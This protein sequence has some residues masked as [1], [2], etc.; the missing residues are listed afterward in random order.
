MDGKKKV[1]AIADNCADIYYKLNRF[2]VTGNSINFALNYKALGGDV[3]CMTILG[4]DAFALTLQ[5]LLSERDVPLKVLKKVDRPSAQ[6][7]MDIVDGN[8]IHV[9]FDG[10]A[11]EEIDFSTDDLDEIRKYDIVY[12]ERWANIGRYIA[13]VKRSD[14]I[15]GYDFSR[16]VEDS[17]NDKI[18]PYIDYAFFSCD[19]NDMNLRKLMQKVRMRGAKVVVAMIGEHGSLAFDGEKFY[20]QAA[21]PA[22]PVNTVGAGDSYIGAFL[23]GISNGRDLQTCM[24]LGTERATKIIQQFEPY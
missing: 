7:T 23:Y 21:M 16:R 2:Y 12:C 22:K 5:M 20:S 9:R 1:I 18:L 14:Q 3:T 6:A 11:M 8:R 17:V 19:C 4:N 10:N 24:R 13:Q 15:W